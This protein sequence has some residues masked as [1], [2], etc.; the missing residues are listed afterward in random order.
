MLVD[1]DGIRTA[2]A[3]LYDYED[4]EWHLQLTGIGEFNWMGVQY[5][6]DSLHI[7]EPGSGIIVGTYG[8]EIYY[9]IHA[10]HRFNAREVEVTF[11]GV[12]PE[13]R[14]WIPREFV[15]PEFSCQFNVNDRANTPEVGSD[16]G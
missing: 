6:F 8:P 14:D 7:A 15:P 16:R 9:K 4:N 5:L 13:R 11:S 12:V 2:Y 3:Y 1:E 10:V